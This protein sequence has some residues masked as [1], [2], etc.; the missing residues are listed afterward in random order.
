MKKRSKAFAGLLHKRTKGH[1][2][3]VCFLQQLQT[4]KNQFIIIHKILPIGIVALL[5]KYCME[6][7]NPHRGKLRCLDM[8]KM[9]KNGSVHQISQC[10]VLGWDVREN[11]KEQRRGRPKMCSRIKSANSRTSYLHFLF[12]LS[13]KKFQ[14][15][16][17]RRVYAGCGKQANVQIRQIQWVCWA[18]NSTSRSLINLPN[19][20]L[21]SVRRVAALC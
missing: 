10:W 13:P 6:L 16:E 14:S 3:M 12:P 21:S 1:P 8:H 4:S 5:V 20:V 18:W 2:L 15:K 17:L 9:N 7:S 11:V 19:L